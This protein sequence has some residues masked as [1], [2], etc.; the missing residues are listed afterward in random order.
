MIRDVALA[1]LV[2]NTVGMFM[3]GAVPRRWRTRRL[4]VIHAMKRCRVGGE[5]K[6]S[7]RRKDAKRVGDSDYDRR[8]SSQF[9]GQMTHSA[10]V[11]D[12]CDPIILTCRFRLESGHAVADGC[13]PHLGL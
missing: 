9:F 13:F 10:I 8:P 11:T 7:R 4:Q 3:R 2:I 1:V 6:R 5:S 12:C